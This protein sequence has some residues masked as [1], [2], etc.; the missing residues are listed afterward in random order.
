MLIAICDDE[1]NFRDSLQSMIIEYK[2]EKRL[3]IDIQTYSDGKALLDSKKVFDIVF[4]DY[5]MPG[6]DGMRVAQEL[7]KRNCI[8]SIV[9][10]TA[11][12]HFVLDSFEVQPF[13][14]FVKPIKYDQIG[15]LMTTYIA[16]QKKLA[17]IIL[18][19][20]DEQTVVSA[21]EI[22]YLEGDGKYCTIRTAN[23]TYSSSKTLAKVHALLPQHCFYRSH[24][25]YVVNLYSVS[26]FDQETITLTNGEIA[27]IGRS[28]TA[29]FKNTYKQFI[30]DYY[31]EI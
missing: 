15:S 16:H 6:M 3:H 24:K 9:F 10:I 17:P 12:P 28:K 22:L 27:R 23:K 20:D 18:I 25:S 30:K 5:Q 4:L 7:R 13:R 29:A 26:S 21:K 14:F 19:N 8:C 31:V 2:R 11:Y 1:K